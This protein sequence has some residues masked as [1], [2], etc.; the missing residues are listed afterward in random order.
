MRRWHWFAIAVVIAAPLTVAG[1]LPGPGHPAAGGTS[2][3][4]RPFGAVSSFSADEHRVLHQAT[5][6]LISECMRARHQEYRPVPAPADHR[7][8]TA[9]PY[10]LLDAGRARTDGYGITA[11]AVDEPGSTTRNDEVVAALPAPERQRWHAALAGTRRQSVALPDG[12]VISYATDGCVFLAGE[13][14]YGAGWTRLS[15][16]FQGFTN[17]VVQATLRD[18]DVVRATARWSDCMRDAG[19]AYATL[20]EP[21]GEVA[22]RVAAAGGRPGALREAG[23]FEL[24]VAR[25]DATCQRH[26]RLPE[27]V[28][29][30]QEAAEHATLT[31]EDRAALDRLRALRSDAL[32]RA[33]KHV[34]AG[35]DYHR[36]EHTW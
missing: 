22:E 28:A 8:T 36:G 19:H 30:A 3:D 15:L 9:S 24:R 11:A 13:R 4:P 31:E 23:A 25:R 12:A 2:P 7:A 20:E 29:A 27:T 33:P 6:Q 21:R 17:A 16:E 1:L 5:E 14:L 10:A 32:A 34:A 35:S 18:A 26:A